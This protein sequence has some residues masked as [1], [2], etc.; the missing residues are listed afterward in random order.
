MNINSVLSINFT[1]SALLE[2]R[3]ISLRNVKACPVLVLPLM[4]SMLKTVSMTSPLLVESSKASSVLQKR[5]KF[6]SKRK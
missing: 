5:Y 3:N 6:N 4:Y 2:F 1:L